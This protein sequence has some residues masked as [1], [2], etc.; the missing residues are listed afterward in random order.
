MIDLDWFLLF[1]YFNSSHKSR[2][3]GRLPVEFIHL[4]RQSVPVWPVNEVALP[5]PGAGEQPSFFECLSNNVPSSLRRP[6]I[7]CLDPWSTGRPAGLLP[8]QRQ[9]SDQQPCALPHR[10]STLQQL[11]YLPPW[12]PDG[13]LP[14]SNSQPVRQRQNPRG[15]TGRR[16]S[17]R[18]FA[19]GLRGVKVSELYGEVTILQV[20]PGSSPGKVWKPSGASE[21]DRLGYR[22]LRGTS[23]RAGPGQTRES[24]LCLPGGWWVIIWHAVF[25]NN[26]I[27]ICLLGL[28]ALT[29]LPSYVCVSCRY[30]HLIITSESVGS[31]F[32]SL[33]FCIYVSFILS[34][35]HTYLPEGW[36]IVVQFA[37]AYELIVTVRLQI[38]HCGLCWCFDPLSCV[39]Q[40]HSD[41]HNRNVL[42]TA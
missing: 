22:K 6:Q 9:H 4:L 28:H 25:L 26:P 14:Y 35:S 13:F 31:V 37:N 5:S 27:F 23:S 34:I 41:T 42:V 38:L 7:P 21:P 33:M 32:H 24:P 16:S 40:S 18:R 19:Q 30:P 1:L 3:A 2:T 12:F 17:S 36:V 39:F 29:W 20:P 10:E 15:Q 8:V 11:G